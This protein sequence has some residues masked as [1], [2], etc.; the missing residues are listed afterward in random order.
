MLI[1]HGQKIR[2]CFGSSVAADPAAHFTILSLTLCRS[3]ECYRW[4][5]AGMSNILLSSFKAWTWAMTLIDAEVL[6]M[7][8]G[9]WS[10]SFPTQSLERKTIVV[11]PFRCRTGVTGLC[12]SIFHIVCMFQ[13]ILLKGFFTNSWAWLN[14]M[15]LNEMN[16]RETDT[17]VPCVSGI[18]MKELQL[19]PKIRV[20]EQGK[21]RSSFFLSPC[22]HTLGQ[23]RN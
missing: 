9:H 23:N 13:M 15:V 22:I 11:S 17:E 18:Q 16:C 2:I 21:F 14:E 7:E 19:S 20:E 1:L 6:G 10:T 5:S 3:Y 8:P 4:L 12:I